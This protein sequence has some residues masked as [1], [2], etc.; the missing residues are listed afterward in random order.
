MNRYSFSH[1]ADGTLLRQLAETVSQDRNTT[2]TLL[3]QMAEVDERR[4]YVPAGYPSMYLYCLH[5][6]H[7]S[8][9]VAF[10]RIRVAR[11]AR[12]IPALFPLLADGR[13]SLSAAV[14]LAPH[15]TPEAADVLLARAV[16]RTNAEIEL[17]LAEQFPKPDVPALVQVI[18]PASVPIESTAQPEACPLRLAVRPVAPFPGS[19]A[20]QPVEPPSMRAKPVPLS[21]GRFAVQFTMDEEMHE[22]LVCVQALLG[23]TLPSGDL[24]QVF[25]RALHELRLKLEKQK[26]AATSHPRRQ[27]QPA[28]GRHIPAAV[29]RAVRERDGGQC[30]FKGDNGRRCESSTRLE[31]DHIVP[32]VRGGQAIASNLRLRCH[33][34]NQYEAERAFGTDFMRAKRKRSNCET[35]AAQA[36]ALHPPANP[37]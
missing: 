2:A 25:R 22:E 3:A 23:H 14:M 5:E 10:K 37:A 24:V 32:Y 21:P 11:V 35:G 7:M 15:L 8:E 26:F 6:L 20:T 19:S 17:L 30:T 1:L 29:K 18:A 33:A 36:T 31:I 16:H 12:K 9:D 13:L 28:K 4:L 34:H 27:T